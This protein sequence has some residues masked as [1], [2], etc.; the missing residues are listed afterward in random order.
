MACY[1]RFVWIAGGIGK[2]G[3]IESLAPLFPRI[4]KA[5]LIGQDGPAFA[6]TLRAHG[7]ANDVAGTLDRAVRLAFAHARAT[8]TE[9]VLFSPAAASFDQFKNFEQRG[10][11]FAALV[12]AA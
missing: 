7:V 9:I 12:R 4:S 1:Q 5:F 11:A 8:G 2:A 3:G 6:E 10:D